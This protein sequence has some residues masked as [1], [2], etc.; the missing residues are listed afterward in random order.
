MSETATQ[1]QAGLEIRVIINS[2]GKVDILN[3]GHLTA[4]V[5]CK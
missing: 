4:F 5:Q 3:T 1:W 2:T